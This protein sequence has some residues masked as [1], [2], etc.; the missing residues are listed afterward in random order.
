MVKKHKI[1]IVD[2]TPEWLKHHL[3]LIDQMFKE[4]VFEIHTATSGRQGFNKVLQ[5]KN[6]DIVITDLEMEK[7]F[8]ED[9]AG[10]WLVRNLLNRDETKN[11]KFL[12]ISGA[13]SIQDIAD[14]LKVDCIAKS[15]L[16]DNPLILK[17]KIEEL[18]YS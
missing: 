8:D 16:L 15:L 12:I 13:Y 18:L 2:D 3:S 6:Y 4:D 14:N 1:L 11:T 7:V 9:Y 5:E 17:Y 10:V